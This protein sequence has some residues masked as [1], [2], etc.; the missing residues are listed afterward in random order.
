MSKGEPSEGFIIPTDPS[1]EFDYF[2]IVRER[3]SEFLTGKGYSTVEAARIALHLAEGA[4]HVLHLLKVMTKAGNTT[5]EEILEA[6]GAA[7]DSSIPLEKA[8][9]VLL[10]R[11]DLDSPEPEQQIEQLE[12]SRK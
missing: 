6:L 4:R 5:D 12:D 3:L 7:L 10:H 9:R 11:D 1:L 2:E 8:K